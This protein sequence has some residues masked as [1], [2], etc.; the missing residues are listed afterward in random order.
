MQAEPRAQTEQR[1]PVTATLGRKP[2]EV[3]LKK[4]LESGSTGLE[5]QIRYILAMCQMNAAESQTQPVIERPLTAREARLYT[6]VEL[7]NELSD[8]QIQS[9]VKEM[10]QLSDDAVRLTLLTQLALHMKPG[11][12]RALVREILEGARTLADPVPRARIL[13]ELAPLLTLVND[14]PATDTTLLDILRMAQSIRN[15]EGRIRSLIA[16]APHL[17]QT[18]MNRIYQRAFSEIETLNN[19]A[20][21]SN[22]IIALADGVPA[23]FYERVL[24]LTHSIE[25]PT[26]RARTMTTL[27]RHM[28]IEHQ[29]HLRAEALTAIGLIPNE[30]QR[31]ETLIGFV[32]NLEFAS[33]NEQY[34]ALLEK[35]L[36]I[37][38]DLTRKHIRVKVL[39][40]LAPHL[41]PDLQGE[42]LA[43][44]HSLD[45]ERERATL[46]AQLAPM[47]PPDMLIASLAVAH[48]MKEQDSRVH[49][50]TVLAHYV[51]EHAR[52]QTLLDALAAASNLPNHYERVRALVSL[53]DI[54]PAHLQEQAFANALETTRL[55]E[56]E[57]AKSRALALLGTHLP[58]TYLERA[59]DLANQ[60][61]DPQQR[62]SAL[63]GIVP[64]LPDSAR[65]DALKTLLETAIGIPFEYKRARA[66]VSIAPLLTPELLKQIMIQADALD[67]P[68]DRVTVYIALSQNMPPQK[69]PPILTKAWKQ[70]KFIDDGYDRASALAAIA[71][72]LPQKASKD[73]AKEA[74]ATIDTILDAYD[75]ASAISILAPMLADSENEAFA[76]LPD[77]NEA[78]EEAIEAIMTIPHQTVRVELLAQAA[79]LWQSADDGGRS[80][81]L[82]RKLGGQLAT[83][84]LADALRCLGALMPLLRSIA[85]DKSVKDVARILGVS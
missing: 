41:T 79:H 18:L 78:V 9:L 36:G 69:R 39:V 2:L 44:V 35:A 30:D 24:E 38:I 12:Y 75:K 46:L 77:H 33:G 1:N 67:D 26:E 34:P 47:L 68:Y 8:S 3:A 28:P 31:A 85:G 19:D 82:W 70:M 56:N 81:R 64:R 55:I 40:T 76:A 51:P 83:L 13:L 73:L 65:A 17:P 48:S 59:L 50:L 23:E 52:S 43:A 15:T 84:P 25:S 14:E 10:R 53:I 22:V 54:L 63:T 32:P 5:Q 58:G 74:T 42:A 27:A 11:Y 37:T 57:N 16:V 62:L 49:A 4:A 72:F 61:T 6:L 60:L 20:S 71:P 7:A 66:L 29:P 80:E 45:S 21:R